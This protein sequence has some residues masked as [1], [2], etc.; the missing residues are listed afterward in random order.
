MD[1]IGTYYEKIQLP[2]RSR[3]FDLIAFQT[4]IRTL[5]GR[6]NKMGLDLNELKAIEDKLKETNDYLAEVEQTLNVYK[7]KVT[8]LFYYGS[9]PPYSEQPLNGLWMDTNN[10]E[11]N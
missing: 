4:I 8:S 11:E 3:D 5:E 9:K 10:G 6:I 2:E 1:L 7:G